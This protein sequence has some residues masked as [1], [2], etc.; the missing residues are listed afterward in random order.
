MA[1]ERAKLAARLVSL[2]EKI[3]GSHSPRGTRQ[4]L[5][6]PSNE[7]R[8]EDV[9]QGDGKNKKWRDGREGRGRGGIKYRGVGSDS[10]CMKKEFCRVYLFI[11][12]E[13]CRLIL[14]FYEKDLFFR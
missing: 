12:L 9:R 5:P 8:A 14:V 1:V 3:P 6:K 4:D 10:R 13:Y 11:V 2:D 7:P